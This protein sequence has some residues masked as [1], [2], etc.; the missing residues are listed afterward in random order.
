MKVNFGKVLLEPRLYFIVVCSLP[1]HT[2]LYFQHVGTPNPRER[3]VQNDANL[4]Q[5]P[6]PSCQH[7]LRVLVSHYYLIYSVK[8]DIS[9]INLLVTHHTWI[10]YQ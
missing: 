3:G 7:F 6:Q 2:M 1:C 5:T 8:I 4:V 9:F 10:R